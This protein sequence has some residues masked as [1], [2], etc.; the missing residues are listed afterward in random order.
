MRQEWRP[1]I[2]AYLGDRKVLRI[3]IVLV[4]ARRGGET[5]EVELLEWLEE[6]TVPTLVVMTKA[7]KLAKSKRKPAAMQLKKA[8]SLS[9]MPLLFSAHTGDGVDDLWRAILKAVA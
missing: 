7:D 8:L 5:E 9:R 1:L 2:E 3:V 4:D 6:M